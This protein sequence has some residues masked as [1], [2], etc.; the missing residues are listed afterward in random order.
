MET[1]RLRTVGIATE[2]IV[3]ACLV[4]QGKLGREGLGERRRVEASLLRSDRRILGLT[5]SSD[6]VHVF[7]LGV[8]GELVS[9]RLENGTMN[10]TDSGESAVEAA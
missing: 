3:E 10:R 7:N 1:F 9:L 4:R 5:S 6:K 2:R 8:L